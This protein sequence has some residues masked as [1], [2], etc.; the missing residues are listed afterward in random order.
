MHAII[1]NTYLW[2]LDTI[3][4][5]YYYYNTPGI[6][7]YLWSMKYKY[8]SV[9]SA[10]GNLQIGVFYRQEVSTG[11]AP[12]HYCVCLLK[13]CMTKYRNNNKRPSG[14]GRRGLHLQPGYT[15]QVHDE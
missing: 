11:R 15:Y 2:Y 13:Y 9:T 10:L 3:I 6:N 12:H 5:Y 1:N 8:Q 4:T 7:Y 14:R